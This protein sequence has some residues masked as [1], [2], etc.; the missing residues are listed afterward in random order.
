MYPGERF[1]SIS[2]MVGA[3]LA[4]VAS[5]VL[6]VR[7]SIDG[8]P[9]KV[10]SFT[11]YGVTLFLLYLISTLYRIFKGRTPAPTTSTKPASF[12]TS[13]PGFI[14]CANPYLSPSNMRRKAL[15]SIFRSTSYS[16]GNVRLAQYPGWFSQTF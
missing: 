13:P 4:A 16:A 10:V 3:V 12:S 14:H 1:N 9:W 7:S 15:N 5:V 11:I 8:D 2:H 6:V